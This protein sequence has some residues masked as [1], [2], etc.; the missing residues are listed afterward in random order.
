M[1]L[2]TSYQGKIAVITGAASGIGRG[3]AEH[4]AKKGMKVVIADIEKEPLEA[5]EILLRN[6]GCE[7]MSV[8]MDVS[9]EEDVQNLA[10]EVFKN[11]R[12]VHFLFNNAAFG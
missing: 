10:D 1:K 2:S 7:V 4:C 6:Y 9:K 11:F 5:F 3:L 12:R 8:L